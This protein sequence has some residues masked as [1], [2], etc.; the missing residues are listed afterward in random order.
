MKALRRP[1][2]QRFVKHSRSSK[3]TTG[4]SLGA[5]ADARGTPHEK[6]LMSPGDDGLGSP[7]SAPVQ[8]RSEKTW[9]GKTVMQIRLGKHCLGY[10]IR[11]RFRT[12][13]PA[14]ANGSD[15]HG[16]E[17]RL[18]E[19]E[20]RVEK[21]GWEKIEGREAD[22]NLAVW[23]PVIPLTLNDGDS[24]AARAGSNCKPVWYVRQRQ[25]SHRD[26]RSLPARHSWAAFRDSFLLPWPS[27][28]PRNTTGNGQHEG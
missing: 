4:L 6:G 21:R 26:L 5:S 28:L 2:V 1:S 24:E 19:T 3:R 9:G 23:P 11:R 13:A 8:V 25:D 18:L 15:S 16:P 22:C 20:R 10:P 12:N 17:C 27:N 14:M 7:F